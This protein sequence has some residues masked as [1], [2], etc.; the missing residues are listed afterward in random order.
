MKLGFS[1][2]KLYWART[3]LTRGLFQSLAVIM[4]WS[5][6]FWGCC[7]ELPQKWSRIFWIRKLFRNSHGIHFIP[8]N[9]PLSDNTSLTS[10]VRRIQIHEK[11]ADSALGFR[12]SHKECRRSCCWFFLQRVTHI[13]VCGKFTWVRKERNQCKE[14]IRTSRKFAGVHKVRRFRRKSVEWRIATC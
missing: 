5:I 8:E 6:H 4:G 10:I 9:S 12:W 11:E 13:N 2:Q 3:Y 14:M 7:K 1:R